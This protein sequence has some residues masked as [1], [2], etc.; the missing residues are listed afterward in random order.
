PDRLAHRRGRR[1]RRPGHR[2]PHR[3]QAPGNPARRPARPVALAGRRPPRTGHRPADLPRPRRQDQRRRN[4]HHDPHRLADV[5][6]HRRRRMTPDQVPAPCPLC[7][8]LAGNAPGELVAQSPEAL[9]LVPLNPVPPGHVLI[10]PR[11][12]VPD[13]TTNPDVSAATMAAAAEYATSANTDLNLITSRGPA[14]TQTVHHLH[15]HLVPR[16]H[17]DALPLPWDPR[18]VH[19]GD[20][21]GLS[22]V[23]ITSSLGM[24]PY[25]RIERGGVAL[26]VGYVTAD[27]RGLA[28][29]RDLHPTPPGLRDDTPLEH[30]LNHHAADMQRDAPM[31]AN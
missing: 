30:R 13:F 4:T 28:P 23:E 29:V 2:A 26:A 18:T 8:I 16:H 17:G 6:L 15:L 1:L 31:T 5:P 20:I 25:V 12:H 10:V 3:A 7:D 21:G 27:P 24:P 14:A 22:R 11:V 19:H 9:A